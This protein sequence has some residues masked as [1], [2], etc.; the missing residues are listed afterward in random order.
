MT[1]PT[2][3]S[4]DAATE[5]ALGGELLQRIDP[6]Q[7]AEAVLAT[8]RPAGIATM[9]ARLT[10]GMASILL[11][12]SPVE[13][14]PKDFRFR[15][16]T[17]RDNAIYHRLAQAYLLWVDEMMRLP[18]TR[19]VDWQ[20][21]ERSRFV[22]TQLTAALA[23]TNTLPG[24]PEA[25]KRV[26]ETSGKSLGR[27]FLNFLSDLTTNRGLPMQVDTTA[28]EVGK[29]LAATPGAVV[30]REEMFEILQYAPTTD[31]VRT[32]PVLLL[33]PPAAV[34]PPV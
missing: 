29:T 3:F 23:P 20:T 13:P 22:M 9:T 6:I 15:D 30:H 17:W 19:D 1:T 12:R 28:F 2:G 31:T 21:A 34:L 11:G 33:P 16:P 27:G 5:A 8:V 4:E 32:V 26:F 7:L 14:A 10:A 18:N 24:N 25:L